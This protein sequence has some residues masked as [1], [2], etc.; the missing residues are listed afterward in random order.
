M[1]IISFLASLSPIAIKRDTETIIKKIEEFSDKHIKINADVE[2]MKKRLNKERNLRHSVQNHIHDMLWAKDL[3]GKYIMVNDAF[4]MNFCYELEENEILGKTDVELANMFKSLVGDSNHT[5]GEIC[6]NS[7]MI[8]HETEE[9]REFL[10]HGK[11]NG[12]VMKLVVSKSPLYNF[13]GIMYGTCGTG[14]DVTEWHN[15]LEKAIKSH[16]NCFGKEGADLLLKEL[17]KM[18]FK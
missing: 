15:D 8:I 5:F 10:E 7:D 2:D 17:N 1:G 11:I 18:E 4:R 13:K 6:G 14:R 3:D 16:K 9:A 12:K